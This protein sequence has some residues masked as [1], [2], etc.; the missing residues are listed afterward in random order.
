[1]HSLRLI[2]IA[3]PVFLISLSS[4][5]QE[6]EKARFHHVHLN[7]TD[8]QKSIDFYRTILSAEPIKFRGVSDALY[9]GRAFILMN[10]VDKA[11]PAWPNTSIWHI[12]WGGVDMESEYK[13]LQKMNVDI[14]VPLYP[15]GR[16]FVT[17]IRDPD[18]AWIE[19]NTQGHHRFS[20]VHLFATD[21]NEMGKWFGDH[22]GMKPRR[23]AEENPKPVGPRG[24]YKD[25]NHFHRAGNRSW[26]NGVSTDEVNIGIYPIPNYDTPPWW[27]FEKI[28]KLEPQKGHAID[29]IA[30]SYRDIEPVFKRMKKAGVHIVE[31]IA[32]RDKFGI[33]SFFVEGPDRLLVEIVEAKPVP[34]GMWD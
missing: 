13:W 14:V 7:V 24:K 34:E 29:H 16:G 6:V 2:V 31:P 5:A 9:M 15:L 20:H 18:E 4:T 17:Y 33:K 25:W 26:S 21:V 10:K 28:M 30:F 27:P 23:T 3:V 1:M 11:P 19:V 32:K 8:P 22:L 12:G